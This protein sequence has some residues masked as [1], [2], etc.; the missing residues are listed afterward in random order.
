MF[1]DCIDKNLISSIAL[2]ENG[3]YKLTLYENKVI[4]FEKE[5]KSFRS[6]KIAETIRNQKRGF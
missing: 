5:Y 2:Q 6:A 3:N 1:I 4:I